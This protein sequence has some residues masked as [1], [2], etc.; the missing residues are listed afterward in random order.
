MFGEI[1]SFVEWISDHTV[2]LVLIYT[3]LVMLG[4]SMLGNLAARVELQKE[5]EKLGLRKEIS[6]KKALLDETKTN[7]EKLI[8]LDMDL[9]AEI[10]ALEEQQLQAGLLKL[11]QKETLEKLKQNKASAAEIAA[12]E[13]AIRDTEQQIINIGAEL[14]LKKEEQRKNLENLEIYKA[15]E[16]VLAKQLTQLTDKLAVLSK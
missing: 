13:Q 15:Q 11:E 9:K 7:K 16:S 6:A 2:G 8:G 14:E 1:L 4:V 5:E 10:N 3:S 12:Q